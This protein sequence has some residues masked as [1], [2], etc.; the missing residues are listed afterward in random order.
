MSRYL[1]FVPLIAVVLITGLAVI[2]HF[3]HKSGGTRVA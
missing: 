2:D 3:R 1:V